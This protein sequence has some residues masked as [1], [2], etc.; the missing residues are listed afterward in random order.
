M[1][2]NF[3]LGVFIFGLLITMIGVYFLY[4]QYERW[5]FHEAHGYYFDRDEHFSSIG[6]GGAVWYVLLKRTWW[7]PVVTLAFG[8]LTCIAAFKSHSEN[9][10][11]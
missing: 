5:S 4:Y 3:N 11:K 7:T 2:K 1:K 10:G 9:L 6:K 8:I